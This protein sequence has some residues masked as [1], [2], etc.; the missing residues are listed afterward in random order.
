MVTTLCLAAATIVVRSCVSMVVAL[1][2][3]PA[4]A[5]AAGTGA[6]GM[7]WRT[8]TTVL[9]DARTALRIAA[10]ATAARP[11]LRRGRAVRTT[12]WT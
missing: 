10:E 7:S 5:V 9:P 6:A 1:V 4:G 8:R 2:V 12:G 11:V 3:D